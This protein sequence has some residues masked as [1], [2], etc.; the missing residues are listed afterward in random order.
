MVEFEG[1]EYEEKGEY[2]DIVDG[3]FCYVGVLFF[4]EGFVVVGG[5]ELEEEEGLDLGV[6]FLEE[7]VEVMFV[8]LDEIVGVFVDEIV[9]FEEF[10]D[11][12]FWVVVFGVVLVVGFVGFYGDVVDDVVK[13]VL[14]Y[15]FGLLV[16]ILDV[17]FWVGR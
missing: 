15:F 3:C 8:D 5:F 17:Y 13:D 16:E 6:G 10:V 14:L 9:Y 11:C 4:G 12:L 2:F 1:G 7:E